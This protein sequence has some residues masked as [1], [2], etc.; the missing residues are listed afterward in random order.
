MIGPG[1]ADHV[2]AIT[3]RRIAGLVAIVALLALGIGLLAGCA[4]APL[5]APACPS[6][7]TYSPAFQS[8]AADEL[9]TLPADAALGTIVADYKRLR[10]Q[11]RACR[12][13]EP[14]S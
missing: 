13:E 2:G 8:K 7:V 11:V 1:F 9:E 3:A 6:L 5:P 12:G 10:D 4:T 14:T